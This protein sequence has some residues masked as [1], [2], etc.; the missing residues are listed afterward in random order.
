[1]QIRKLCVLV[2]HRNCSMFDRFFQTSLAR[3]IT[4]CACFVM[5]R[6]TCYHMPVRLYNIVREHGVG[7]HRFC[8]TLCSG[9]DLVSFP[10]GR[11][12]ILGPELGIRLW[13]VDWITGEIVPLSLP[14]MRAWS[15]FFTLCCSLHIILG[16]ELRHQFG[17]ILLLNVASFLYL[18]CTWS[19]QTFHSKTIAASS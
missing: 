19:H 14:S 15:F 9:L 10:L 4:R 5:V 18:L 1:M 6:Y 7:T 11:T 17:N 13:F 12:S 2:Y 16:I 8:S 3:L